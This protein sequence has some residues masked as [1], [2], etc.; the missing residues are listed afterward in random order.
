MSLCPDGT[1]TYLYSVQY[2]EV[3][4]HLFYS[5]PYLSVPEGQPPKAPSC[6]A[7]HRQPLNICV[8]DRQLICGI[9]LTVGQHQGHPIDNLQAAFIRERQAPA[10]LLARLSDHRRAEVCE[11]GEQ[12]KASCEGLV[13][14]AVE[15]YFQGLELVLARKKDF[16]GGLGH[17]K[18][19]GVSGLRSTH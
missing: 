2:N 15:Q 12:D 14:Q 19:G 1:M 8:Q 3:V 11:L 17:R 16:H 4:Y 18:R 13:R 10:H 7:H 5:H 9:C 6:P